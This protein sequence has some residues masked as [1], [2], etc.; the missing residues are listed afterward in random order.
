MNILN[1]LKK[2]KKKELIIGLLVLLFILWSFILYS[3]SPSK[4]IDAV[5]IHNSYLIVIILGFLGGTSLL[6]PFPYYLFVITFAAGGSNPILLGICAGIGVVIGE[7]TS[8]FVGYHGREI[9]NEKY[10]KLFSKICKYCNRKENTTLLS[11]ILFLYGAF[12]PLPN[13]FLI[14]PLGA[15]RYGYWKLIIPL[16]LGNIIFNILLAYSGI[17]GWSF[18]V[19]VK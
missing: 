15:A 7:S 16:G 5:G 18:F 8:Y 9:F 3:F 4:I 11:I 6:F 12:I 17:Y 10:Q 1:F 2:N 13:D 19:N 14:L